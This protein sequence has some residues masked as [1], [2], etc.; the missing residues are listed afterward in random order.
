MVSLRS[1]F[2]PLEKSIVYLAFGYSSFMDCLGFIIDLLGSEKDICKS[3]RC[4]VAFFLN[5][6]S[7]CSFILSSRC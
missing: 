5:V 3:G 6:I 2:S 7:I 1:F 4:M